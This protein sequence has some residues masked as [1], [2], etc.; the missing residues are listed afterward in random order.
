MAGRLTGVL[1][2]A[3]LL[4]A[5]P[6]QGAETLPDPTRPPAAWLSRDAAAD[7]AVAGRRLQTV[8]VPKRGKPVAV[9]GGQRVALGELYGDAKVVRI[10]EKEVVLEGPEGREVLELVPDVEKR[11]ATRA[12]SGSS[13]RADRR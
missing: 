4:L 11:P 10:S 7:P 2:A 12:K 5:L 1:G 13:A 8:I 6:A 9:I 3:S